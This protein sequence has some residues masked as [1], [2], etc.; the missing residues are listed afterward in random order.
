MAE[1]DE[2]L[3]R[4]KLRQEIAK[5]FSDEDLKILCFDLSIDYDNLGTGGK[6]GKIPVLIG[7]C[8]RDKKLPELL[9]KL[10]E[11][12]PHITWKSLCKKSER[13]TAEHHIPRQPLF[14]ETARPER[15]KTKPPTSGVNVHGSKISTTGTNSPIITSSGPVIFNPPPSPPPPL[16]KVRNDILF[17]V[18]LVVIIIGIV[19]YF[20]QMYPKNMLPTEIAICD[21]C[22]TPALNAPTTSI[23]STPTIA[24]QGSTSPAPPT[25]S[26][27]ITPLPSPA[28]LSETNAPVPEINPPTATPIPP[29]DTP[30][31]SITIPDPGN[32][33][34]SLAYTATA[35]ATPT[36]TFTPTP[37]STA[38][39][40]PSITPT[41]T[42]TFTPT[43]TIAPSSTNT[44]VPPT[45]TIPPTATPQPTYTHTPI[46][47]WVGY[48][49]ESG[50]QG[51]R[52]N[53]GCYPATLGTDSGI[54]YE[55]NQALVFIAELAETCAS[56][57]SGCQCVEIEKDFY[58]TIPGMSTP[59]PYNLTGKK[60]SCYVYL[61][62][63]L[64]SPGNPQ[65]YVTIY[66]K[67]SSFK[68]LKGHAVNVTSSN[69]D[70]W[71]EL[72]LVIG[73]P[74]TYSLIETG[75]GFDNV[76]IIGIRVELQDNSPFIYN[77]PI[78]IDYCG[79]E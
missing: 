71:S 5:A 53:S 13:S 6:A 35:S 56:G 49:F 10:E 75:F 33:P 79:I 15:S 41:L 19:L 74:S 58:Y 18:V 67:D 25:L 60:V 77:G 1:L 73:D 12:R 21:F 68:N 62:S 17:A 23:Q 31:S 39:P 55:G 38:T 78:Y 16:R 47:G 57:D 76:Y 42:P 61:P 32:T 37:S 59:G 65:V 34:V 72:S 29:T 54:V 30:R 70:Q 69:V 50:V 46:P 66:V 2:N 14:Q 43:P 45:P 52:N 27:S 36:Q 8:T 28:L 4:P 24:G 9:K 63:G 22:T 44:P 20:V 11:E 7:I 51:W 40:T 48:D 3:D 26:P 64:L